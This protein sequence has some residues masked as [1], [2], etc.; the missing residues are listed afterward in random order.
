MW[1]SMT[2][3]VHSIYTELTCGSVGLGTW[4]GFCL[5]LLFFVLCV[6]FLRPITCPHAGVGHSSFSLSSNQK[7]PISASRRWSV[8]T[9]RDWPVLSLYPS[10]KPPTHPSF[11]PVFPSA[12]NVLWHVT[13]WLMSLRLTQPETKWTWI[14]CSSESNSMVGL[15]LICLLESQFCL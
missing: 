9:L 1:S 13:D 15:Y 6:V 10:V 11:P 7:L 2:F 12:T 8:Q 14:M 5:F 3:T 4:T